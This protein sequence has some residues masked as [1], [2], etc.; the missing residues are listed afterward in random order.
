MVQKENN[1][2]WSEGP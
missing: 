1:G 2:V